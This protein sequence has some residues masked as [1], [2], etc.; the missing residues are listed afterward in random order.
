MVIM[1]ERLYRDLIASLNGQL[2]HEIDMLEK[3]ISEMPKRM[4]EKYFG[5]TNNISLPYEE[6]AGLYT[7]RDTLRG[8]ISE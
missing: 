8:I 3:K 1:E 2:S 5:V 6:L 4:Q 7:M